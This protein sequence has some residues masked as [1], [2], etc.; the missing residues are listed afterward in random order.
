MDLSRSDYEFLFNE[1][2]FDETARS[3][4]VRKILDGITFEK[5]AEEF[6]MSPRNVQYIVDKYRKLILE[7]VEE[8][9]NDTRLDRHKILYLC[10]SLKYNP[11]K[12]GNYIIDAYLSDS[13]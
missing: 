5:V 11:E 4:M 3:V 12:I 1:W 6:N 2:I 13:A 7:K 10:S 8:Y 9:E